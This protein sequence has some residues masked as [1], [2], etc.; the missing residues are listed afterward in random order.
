MVPKVLGV[1]APATDLFMVEIWVNKTVSPHIV[2]PYMIKDAGVI[3]NE[4]WCWIELNKLK[5][6]ASLENVNQIMLYPLPI[7][8]GNSGPSP[9]PNK[10]PPRNKPDDT[11]ANSTLIPTPAE[12]PTT[13]SEMAL[14]QTETVNSS[15]QN[16]G[17]KTTPASSMSIMGIGSVMTAVVLT[18]LLCERR[19]K[20]L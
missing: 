11:L 5:D 6:I 14:K 15:T 13:Q 8:Y 4:I 3:D 17:I 20:E 19:K 18:A 1:K 10:E 7:A 2:D 16:T 12:I 9:I